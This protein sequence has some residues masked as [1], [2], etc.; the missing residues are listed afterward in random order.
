MKRG[1]G[2]WR[3]EKGVSAEVRKDRDLFHGIDPLEV[4]CECV[5]IRD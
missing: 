5:R 1:A 3:N 2:S 4:R